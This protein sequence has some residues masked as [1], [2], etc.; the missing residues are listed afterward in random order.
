MENGGS[1]ITTYGIKQEKI[2]WFGG[3]TDDE[4]DFKHIQWKFMCRY[5]LGKWSS[6]KLGIQLQE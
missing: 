3:G 4:F 5:L 6:V 2:E 1:F